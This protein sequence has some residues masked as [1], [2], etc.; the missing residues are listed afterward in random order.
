MTSICPSGRVIIRGWR[1]WQI[2]SMRPFS[3]GEVAK[4]ARTTRRV[5][6]RQRLWL[7]ALSGWLGC[8]GSLA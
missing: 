4:S 7:G 8:A 1:A 5:T 6:G 2:A 3:R